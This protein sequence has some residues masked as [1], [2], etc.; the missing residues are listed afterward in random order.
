[1]A[2]FIH[3]PLCRRMKTDL[4]QYAEEQIDQCM[5][6]DLS[7]IEVEEKLR[8]FNERLQHC[9]TERRVGAMML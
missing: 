8:A 1:M 6:L 3:A 9:A 2:R 4:E 7:T 5:R